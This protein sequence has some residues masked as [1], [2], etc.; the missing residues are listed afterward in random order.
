M[1]NKA[2]KDG[3]VADYSPMLEGSI[4]SMTIVSG[5]FLGLR[6]FAKVSQ[7]RSLWWDDHFLIVSWV[8]STLKHYFPPFPITRFL[9]INLLISS[10]LLTEGVKY[11]I[12]MHFE[13]MVL[14][15][16]PKVAEFSYAAGFTT[17]LG[18]AWSKTSF[19]ITLLR[20]STGWTKW[21]VWF[22]VISINLVLGA[23]AIILFI[24]CWPIQKLF[25]EMLDGQCWPKN[26]VEHY[27]MFCSV[28]SGAMDIILAL[29]PWKIVWN[30]AIFRREKIG[31][32]VAMSMGVF[33]GIMSFLKIISLPDIS[34]V[35]STTIDL[36]ILGIAELATTIIAVSIP[37]LRAFIRRKAPTTARLK[38]VRM[39][40]LPSVERSRGHDTKK[41]AVWANEVHPNDRCSEDWPEQ[42]IDEV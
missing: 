25:N 24:Q 7:K 34:D 22:L 12:G 3:P 39:S 30:V 17:I 23:S 4:W 31:A 38:F 15:N 21:F 33:S 2:N 20:I 16:I 32:L 41:T 1:A 27:Q 11:G 6:V 29:L 8:S 36:K 19:G 37:V 28:Y 10:A 40:Q 9:R 35:K 14:E 13:D 5:L 18:T 42:R 26:T